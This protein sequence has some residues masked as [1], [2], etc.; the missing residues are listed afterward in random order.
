MYTCDKCAVEYAHRINL[1]RHKLFCGIDK[2]VK[3]VICSK[4]FI[5]KHPKIKCCSRS[6]GSVYV[7]KYTDIRKRR[8][9]SKLGSKNPMWREDVSYGSLHSWVRRNKFNDG[10]CEICLQTKELQI[11][12][13]DHKYTRELSDWK[14]L[15]TKCHFYFDKRDE[16]LKETIQNNKTI[17]LKRCINCNKD[18]YGWNSKQKFC[19]SKCYNT[20]WRK[21]IKKQI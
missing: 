18:F 21:Q 9:D 10:K 16:K 8:S 5:K 6:C 1:F 2:R 19:E 20:K 11:A 14:W 4:L 17:K 15:C 7:L 3:C 12:S 13:I